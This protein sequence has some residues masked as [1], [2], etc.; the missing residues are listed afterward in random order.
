MRVKNSMKKK[1]IIVSAI[2]SMAFSMFTSIPT[3]SQAATYTGSATA[4]DHNLSLWYKQPATNWMTS[5]LPIGNGRLGAMV[6]GDVTQEHLQFNESSL[7][8]GS[9]TS[10]GSYQNFGGICIWIFP[11]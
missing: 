5:A 2:I 10:A 8:T 4:P 1:A 9:K 3:T 7:W 6:F 11:Q